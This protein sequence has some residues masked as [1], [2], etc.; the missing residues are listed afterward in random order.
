[1]AGIAREA[2]RIVTPIDEFMARVLDDPA[3]QARLAA[4]T[5]V[6]DYV[7]IAVALAAEY[8]IA[9]PPGDVE[10]L[11]QPDP[12]GLSRFAP[13]PVT[14]DRW[15]GPGWLPT[16]SVPHANPPAFDWAW[17]GD[18]PLREPMYEDSVRNAA[19]LPFNRMF[20][21]RTSLDAL[22]GDAAHHD[23]AAPSGFV[24]H[25]SRCGSTLA[26]RM[27]MAVPGHAVASEPEPL[28]AVIQWATLSGASHDD[29]VAALRA[30]VGALGRDRT[31]GQRRFFIKFDAWH[32]L[33][34]PLIRAAFPDVPWIFLYRDPVEVIMSHQAEPGLHYVPGVLPPA[35]IGI[36]TADSTSP[37]DYTARILARICGAAVDHWPL[38]GGLA[39]R[40]DD[41]YAAMTTT[42][43]AH[44]GFRTEADER[45]AMTAATAVDAKRPSAP[46]T[47]D[48]VAK[49]KMA[50][51]DVIAAA[52]HVAPH[53]ASLDRLR[54]DSV[55]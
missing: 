50:S 6:P 13:A 2:Q 24:F 1:M 33:A 40:F 5:A 37:A 3:A 55:R 25:M 22:I 46:F 28:D 8:G 32:A 16:R 23:V 4:P 34:L 35:L 49:Q 54:R 26:G 10:A 43:P 27:L 14:L 20:R 48:S 45:A 41:I 18:A 9:L 39:V 53:I 21:T 17:F 29:R 36:D 38:G 7:E 30:I 31:V 15:P 11:L 42:V 44:F 52:A 47:P 12:L 51:A 19:A